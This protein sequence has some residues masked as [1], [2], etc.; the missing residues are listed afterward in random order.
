MPLAL[1]SF[2]STAHPLYQLM[3]VEEKAT[4][5]ILQ[6]PMVDT[7]RKPL[8]KSVDAGSTP[9]RHPELSLDSIDITLEENISAW[10][11]GTIP[12]AG[13]ASVG[14]PD[15]PATDEHEQDG[16]TGKSLDDLLDR[17]CKDTREMQD[18]LQLFVQKIDAQ[19]L[20]LGSLSEL[21]LPA[22]RPPPLEVVL[23]EGRA[24]A[25]SA[26]AAENPLYIASTAPAELLHS[27]CSSK[28]EMLYNVNCVIQKANEQ[29]RKFAVLSTLVG[30]IYRHGA[31]SSEFIPKV[32]HRRGHTKEAKDVDRRQAD[33][34]W[35][36][37]TCGRLWS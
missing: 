32:A 22:G 23:P 34:E 18:Q 17:F 29:Q 10:P 14:G 20:K 7:P 30:S 16:V 2:L 24:Q 9:F 6:S 25:T 11:T 37:L 35:P 21:L 8:N 12:R 28:D 26:T 27:L 31:S 3:L 13:L 19:D 36:S 4:D 5:E 33:A 15:V 1:P